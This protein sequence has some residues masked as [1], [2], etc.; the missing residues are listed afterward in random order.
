MMPAHTKFTTWQWIFRKLL[1][2]LDYGP[3]IVDYQFL[4]VK[5]NPITVEDISRYLASAKRHCVPN[6]ERYRVCSAFKVVYVLTYRTV[7]WVGLTRL[8][9]EVSFVS[10]KC[11]NNFIYSFFI[12]FRDNTFK[13]TL[14]INTMPACNS[15]YY[16][17]TSSLPPVRSPIASC[18][19][20]FGIVLVS[21]L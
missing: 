20:V 21:Q 10:I 12:F 11:L 2:V 13:V 15:I 3:V 7:L 19:F 16:F 6:S 1:F 17:R 8:I 4:L 14:K 9:F 5:L 18:R